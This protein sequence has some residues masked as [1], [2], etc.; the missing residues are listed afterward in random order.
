[1]FDF[2]KKIIQRK[3]KPPQK[4][5]KVVTKEK[6]PTPQKPKKVVTKEKKPTPQKPKKVVTKEKKPTPQK[7]SFFGLGEKLKEGLT[8]TR[9]TLSAQ[10]TDLF[11]SKKIDDS[12]YDEL[13]M[14]LLTADV[15]IS[16][17]SML[18]E[19]TKETVKQEK[20]SDPLELKKILKNHLVDLLKKIE[21][22]LTIS[23]SRPFVIMIVGVN[24]AGKTTTIGKLTKIFQS[25]KKQVLIA[26]GDTFRAAAVEQL[27]IW[28]ERNNTQ[29]IA[30]QNGD[31]SAVIFDAVNSA[32]SKNLD[33]VLA[34]TA[35]RL[36][37]QKNLIDEITKI[38]RVIGKCHSE[39]PQEVMLVI[40]ANTGQNAINQ[41]KIFNDALNVTGLIIT[42]LDG[43]AKGGIVAAIAKDHPTPL[44]YVGVGEKI[45]D[46]RVFNAKE[47]V[48]AMIK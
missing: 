35:G 32:K 27:S 17:T 1:M 25:Q 10:F 19:K 36:P 30:Q 16:A 48:E 15:G 24:G 20:I 41:L 3:D 4:P 45:D 8:K 44:R 13:E 31:P 11:T 38:K 43:T 6:K 21:Q 9:E 26:A 46:L 34:D 14:I 29:V 39:A 47:Y 42:K 33:V 18:I 40:D 2:L 28:G 23:D 37:T 12:F 22:P 7:P 5:K